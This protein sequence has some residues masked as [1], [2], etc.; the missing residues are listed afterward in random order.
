MKSHLRKKAKQEEKENMMKM[1]KREQKRIL[2]AINWINTKRILN[3]EKITLHQTMTHLM[4][5]TIIIVPKVI[6]IIIMHLIK[7][8]QGHPDRKEEA[9]TMKNQNKEDRD[10]ILSKILCS[11]PFL[12]KQDFIFIFCCDLLRIVGGVKVL[13]SKQLEKCHLCGRIH[14]VLILQ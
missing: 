7:I 2:K 4:E 13:L 14:Q 3:G 5:K 1:T 12:I 11:F 8:L 9:Q 10:M 6:T